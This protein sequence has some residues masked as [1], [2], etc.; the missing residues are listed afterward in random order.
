MSTTKKAKTKIAKVKSS[1]TGIGLSRLSPEKRIEIARK[2]GLAISQDRAHMSRISMLAQ[3]VRK[4][5]KEAK[6]AAANIT[7]P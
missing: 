4:R 7:T 6:L 3:E 5:N 1:N 2:G